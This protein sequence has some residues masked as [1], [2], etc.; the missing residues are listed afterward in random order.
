MRK[1]PPIHQDQHSLGIALLVICAVLLLLSAAGC[2]SRQPRPPQYVFVDTFW[3]DTVWVTI[4]VPAQEITAS[5]PTAQVVALAPGQSIVL[6]DSIGTTGQISIERLP[7]DMLHI[8]ARV[9]TFTIRD[10]IYQT[11]TVTLRAECP[12]PA[13]PPARQRNDKPCPEKANNKTFTSVGGIGRS[14]AVLIALFPW[15]LAIGAGI[16]LWRRYLGKK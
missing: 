13:Y 1:R 4:P 7:E 3:H 14:W 8:R 9:D 5:V 15:T 2:R 6:L 11:K 10:T 16:W 12:T